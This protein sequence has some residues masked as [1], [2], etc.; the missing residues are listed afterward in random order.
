MFENVH[1]KPQEEEKGYEEWLK[2]KEDYY[3]KDNIEKSRQML[4]N[5]ITKK[6]ELKYENVFGNTYYDL[7]EAH[8]N[9]IIGID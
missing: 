1:I 2:S 9:T 8:K 4:L 5:T 6:E 3:D 7:K